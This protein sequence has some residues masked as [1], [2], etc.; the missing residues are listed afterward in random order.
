[1]AKLKVPVTTEDHIQGNEN[2][3]ITLVEYG[4]YECPDCF[5]AAPIVNQIRAKFADR[6]RF[7]FRHFPQSAI[8]PH[9]SVAAQ[10]AEAAG[11]QGK[12]WE[13]HDVLFKHQRDLIDHDCLFVLWLLVIHTYANRRRPGQNPCAS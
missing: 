13:M 5:H 1:M 3:S 6:L 10:A 8:H 12:F 2:A 4:D 7:A 9:A 11:G